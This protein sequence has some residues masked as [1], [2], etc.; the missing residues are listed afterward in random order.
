MRQHLVRTALASALGLATLQGAAAA[1]LMDV[2]RAALANDRDLAVAQAAQAAAQPKRDQAAALWRPQVGLSASVGLG[3]N[4]TDSRGAQFS[5]PGL[6][7]ASGADF[8]TSVSNGT[9]A[10]W[11]V[12]AVQPLYN[13]QR[14]VQQEQLALAADLADLEAGGARQQLMLQTSQ[15][16]LELAL[17]DEGVRLLEAQLA[18]A[19]RSSTEAE[20][21][22][23]LGDVPAT[24]VQ[25]ARARLA[26]L[27]AQ[28][29]ATRSERDLERGRLAD[30]TGLAA[31]A[32]ST[33]LPAARSATPPRALDD[34]LADADRANPGLR[35]RRLALA[36]AAK[37]ADKHSR[38]ASATLDLVAQA[39]RERLAGQGDFG[40][41]SNNAS[42]HSI[43][44][45]LTVPLYS[46]GMRD[47]RGEEARRQALKTEAELEQSRQQVAQQVRSAWQG[48]S[49]GTER[50]QALG[51]GLAASQSR[52]DATALG[53]Q[54]G[55][56]TTQDLLNADN[57]LAAARLAQAQ[58]RVALLLARL[59]LAA[60]AGQ[61]D[62]GQL[63]AANG[64]LEPAVK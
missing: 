48:L 4:R 10:R 7:T 56:R 18:S 52:R 9:A 29:V 8:S 17:A 12:S 3:S 61:L 14:R 57:D 43:G 47:A 45:L 19:Q 42:Q 44:V 6:G 51:E 60:L 11:S 34:W 22:F 21:R 27:R 54:V 25:E 59:R 36:I 63:Q 1:D 13:P 35:V 46:G 30:S 41:A 39:G 16:Y 24:D 37:E 62:E 23:R 5:A 58:A 32:L 38:R 15:R 2:W 28:L 50:R 64:E 53:L 26:G 55:H 20:D 31:T 40:T 49:V 33:R